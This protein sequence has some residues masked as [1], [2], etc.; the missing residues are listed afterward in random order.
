MTSPHEVFNQPP[1]LED[2]NLYTSDPVLQDAVEQYGATW[3]GPTLETFGGVIGSRQT[4]EWADEANRNEPELRAFDRYGHRIDEVDYHPSYHRLMSLAVEN[5]IHSMP[6]EPGEGARHAARAAL[7]FLDA[8]VELGH[9]CPISMTYAVLPVLRHEPDLAAEWEPRILSRTYDRRFIP[10][11]DKDGVIAGMTLTEKQGGSDLRSNTTTAEPLGDGLYRV[12]GHKWFCSAPMSDAFVITAQAPDGLTTFWLPRWFEGQRNGFHIQR[13][14]DKMG[15]R[16]NAS[17]EIELDGAIV[18]RIGEE[19]LAVK[20]ISQM[21]HRTRFDCVVGSAALM[22][23]SLTEAAHH[24]RHRS[25]FGK[26]LFEQPLM[27]NVVA[28]LVVESEATLALMMRLAASF[29]G[30]GDP[31]EDAFR[32]IAL[33]VGKYWAGKRGPSH[34][35]EALESLGGMGYVEE[36]PLAR[37]YREA[38]LYGIWEGSG[39]VI[40]LDVLRSINKDPATGEAFIAELEKASGADANL[41]AAI[42][43]VTDMINNAGDAQTDAR[44]LV[45]AMAIALEGSLLARHSPPE[46]SDAFIATRVAG[47]HGATFGTMPSSLAIAR[48]VD[49]APT[50]A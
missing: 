39:N 35:G 3:A 18:R 30:E 22:R 16:S 28:D 33:S 40:C 47:D 44:R 41:D 34:V 29:D 14:K 13:L 11:E 36:G 9:G 19:G 5:G 12:T 2:W 8:Q 24:T 7:F 49:R 45:E 38:P 50:P 21:L 27:A 4:L 1:M 31:Q 26:P 17:S 6:E 48:L 15:N 37:M 10:A 23:R 32:R 42:D 25:A 46:I 43:T 20:T